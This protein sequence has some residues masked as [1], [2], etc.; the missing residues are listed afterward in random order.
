MY[1]ESNCKKVIGDPSEETP[2]EKCSQ[3][4]SGCLGG[5]NLLPGGQSLDISVWVLQGTDQYCSIGGL[6]GTRPLK[7]GLFFWRSRGTPDVVETQKW[8]FHICCGQMMPFARRTHFCAWR[9]VGIFKMLHRSK[10]CTA[11]QLDLTFQKSVLHRVKYEKGR[12]SF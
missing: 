1:Y 7:K 11:T 6:T 2:K 8:T 10:V 4:D 12:L 3:K 9:N 5:Q